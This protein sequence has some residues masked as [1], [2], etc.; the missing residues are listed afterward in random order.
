MYLFTYLEKENTSGEGE[1]KG[2]EE[3]E[4]KAGPMLSAA[5][6]GLDLM[7]LNHD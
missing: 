6:L 1:S 2:E 4:A 7:T 3:R 5:P